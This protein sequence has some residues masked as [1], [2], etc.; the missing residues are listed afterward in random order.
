MHGTV[1][2]IAAAAALATMLLS[3]PSAWAGRTIGSMRIYVTRENDTLVDIAVDEGL[4]FLELKA[5]NPDVDV[6]A[7]A[8][9]T[10]VTIPGMHL[11]PDV[12]EKGIVI[13]LADMRL[14]LFSAGDVMSWPIG[15][16]REG[17]ITPL[18]VT[19]AVRKIKDPVWYPPEL[20]PPGETLAPRHGGT[21]TR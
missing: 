15:V 3:V 19:R 2:M 21:G 8:A 16:G 17:R 10:R 4:G 11:L 9:G 14:Y 6:W 1:R 20:G 7:P 18:G 13:N 5:A 12:P